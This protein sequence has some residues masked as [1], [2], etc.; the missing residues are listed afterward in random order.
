MKEAGGLFFELV[1][2]VLSSLD[3]QQSTFDPCLFY[4][5]D[6][7]IVIWV[8]DWFL[9]GGRRTLPR[10]IDLIKINFK[11]V[12]S[13]LNEAVDFIE[14]SWRKLGTLALS[15]SGNILRRFSENLAMKTATSDLR[16]YCLGLFYTNR[17]RSV[18]ILSYSTSACSCTAGSLASIFNSP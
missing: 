18:T 12:V 9:T 10:A 2:K 1:L 13:E 17:R 14:V 16:R 11:C 5:S 4:A 7:L 15:R 8:D 3:F 6:C